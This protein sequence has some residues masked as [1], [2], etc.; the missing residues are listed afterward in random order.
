MLNALF[1]RVHEEHGDALTGMQAISRV[2]PIFDKVTVPT[3]KIKEFTSKVPGSYIKDDHLYLPLPDELKRRES[4]DQAF[5]GF[6]L[7][8][9]VEA[10]FWLALAKGNTAEHLL[11]DAK[12]YIENLTEP[13]S[14]LGMAF[15]ALYS[16]MLYQNSEPCLRFS[17]EAFKAFCHVRCQRRKMHD[18]V[19]A[20]HNKH[21][22][23][24]CEP[25]P[26]KPP[27]SSGA[28]GPPSPSGAAVRERGIAAISRALNMRVAE[29]RS[30]VGSLSAVR[31]F[32]KIYKL[33]TTPL[34]DLA[35]KPWYT[36][37]EFADSDEASQDMLTIAY[38]A[39]CISQ[40]AGVLKPMYATTHVSS[41]A[42]ASDITLN[43][44]YV[45]FGKS[46][47]VKAAV[48][49]V[50]VTRQVATNV[51][52]ASARGLMALHLYTM[53][54]N[55]LSFGGLLLSLLGKAVRFIVYLCSDPGTAIFALD[56]ALYCL[57]TICVINS[58]PI[59]AIVTSPVRTITALPRG[60][61]DEVVGSYEDFTVVGYHILLFL[62]L[63]PLKKPKALE[64][65]AG[66]HAKTAQ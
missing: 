53:Q 19:S 24:P 51:A 39:V 35:T 40:L 58:L 14:A 25:S 63:L 37:H 52:V 6:E 46:L 66:H 47:R 26:S 43:A 38:L 57:V 59:T 10:F 20:C 16:T 3:E 50:S 28:A 33:A 62:G 44:A 56:R 18:G 21:T 49:A 17:V 55:A 5:L 31:P 41:I 45:I 9:V 60:I 36:Q 2:M 48:T 23:V 65:G 13:E 27:S 22:P 11:K 32:K 4:S 30:Y 64:E 15:R 54:E 8:A 7:E 42:G 29:V 12:N 61:I 1:A 34:Y